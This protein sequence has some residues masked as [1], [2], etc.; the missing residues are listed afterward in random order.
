MGKVKA[1]ENDLAYSDK[2]GLIAI[3]RSASSSA[4]TVKLKSV[5]SIVIRGVPFDEIYSSL[6]DVR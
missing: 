6:A 3:L 4:L 1:F 5:N 2:L